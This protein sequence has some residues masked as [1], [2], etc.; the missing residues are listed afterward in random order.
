MKTVIEKQ[1]NSIEGEGTYRTGLL[2]DIKWGHKEQ[3]GMLI[4]RCDGK[5]KIST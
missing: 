3:D 2:Q 4:Q 1:D 5:Q